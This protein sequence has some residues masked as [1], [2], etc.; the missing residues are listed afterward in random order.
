MVSLKY[1]TLLLVCLGRARD[2]YTTSRASFIDQMVVIDHAIDVSGDGRLLSIIIGHHNRT[3]CYG[4]ITS[5][6]VTFI[7]D[8]SETG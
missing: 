5:G 8:F 1:A 2:P 3:G 7:K 4:L 6:W